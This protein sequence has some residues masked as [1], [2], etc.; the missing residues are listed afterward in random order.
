[1]V[2]KTEHFAKP[3]LLFLTIVVVITVPGLS[4]GGPGDQYELVP[5]FPQR[6]RVVAF[7]KRK[8]IWREDSAYV[9]FYVVSSRYRR[10]YDL[11]VL[12]AKTGKP[13]ATFPADVDRRLTH[14]KLDPKIHGSSVRIAAYKWHGEDEL[15]YLNSDGEILLGNIKKNSCTKLHHIRNFNS[16][17]AFFSEKLPILYYSVVDKGIISLLALNYLTDKT[18][19]VWSSKDSLIPYFVWNHSMQYLTELPEEKALLFIIPARWE[20]G[21]SDLVLH[22]VPLEKSMQPTIRAMNLSLDSIDDAQIDREERILWMR[23]RYKSFDDC[24]EGILVEC[25]YKYD[26]KRHRLLEA[27]SFLFANG[28]IETW[29]YLPKHKLHAIQVSEWGSLI[30]KDENGELELVFD[31][32]SSHVCLYD[33]SFTEVVASFPLEEPRSATLG[34]FSPCENYVLVQPD[35]WHA[36]LYKFQRKPN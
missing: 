25:F 12:D 30:E 10:F 6:F 3:G 31:T 9:A 15:I 18:Q 7:C 8:P 33:M 14:E 28:L 35:L 11:V 32:I 13:V 20:N 1:M 4:T 2:P 19:L 21:L 23:G 29:Q 16:G 17:R 22:I 24:D 27:K 36:V 5:L 26:I 34:P